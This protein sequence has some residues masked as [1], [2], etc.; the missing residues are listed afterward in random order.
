MARPARTVQVLI[1]GSVLFTFISYWRTAAIVLCDLGSTCYYIGG[2]VE[3]FIGKAAPWFILGVM[4]FSLAMN[5]VYVESC[6]LFVRGGVYRVVKE[7]LGGF[8]GKLAVSAL[9]FDYILTGPIS[10]VSAGQYIMG[11]LLETARLVNPEWAV[12][13]QEL[14]TQIRSIGSVLIAIGITLYFFRR[15]LLG[16][17]ESSLTALRIIIVT[18]VMGV[19]MIVWCLATLALRDPQLVNWDIPATPDLNKRAEYKVVEGQDP[20]TGERLAIYEKDA[21]GNLVIARDAVGQP[22]PKVNPATGAQEDPLGFIGRWLPDLAQR[23]RAP[24]NW[25]TLIGF[26][27][28]MIAFGHS[29]LAMSGMETMAQVYREVESPKMPNFKKASWI[30]FFFSFTLT[31]SISF[32]AVM[33]IPDEVRIKYYG[34][35]LIGGLA[36]HVVGPNGLRLALNAFVVVVGFLLLSGAVN[37]SIIGSNGVLN[38]VAEDGVIPAWLQRPHRK[39]GTTYRL[40]YLIVGLQILT[41]IASQGDV[42]VLGEAYAFGVIWSFTFKTM[43]MVVL[44]F[45]DKS[46]RE[47]RVP[48]NLKFGSFELPLGLILIFLALL[49]TALLNLMTKEVATVSGLAFTAI[50]LFIFMGTEY[51][52][53][54]RRRQAGLGQR[55]VEQFNKQSADVIAPEALGLD[56][57]YRKLVAIRSPQNLHMLEKALAEADPETT[58]V[59]VMTAKVSPPGSTESRP[60]DELDT[61]D[62]QLMTAVVAKAEKAGKEVLPLIVPTNNPVFA[63]I[64]TARDL[65]AQELIM[66]ASNKYTAEE[67]LDQVAFYWTSLPAT[68][69]AG[70][71][72]QPGSPDAWPRPITIRILGR[73]WDTHIDLNGGARI[74]TLRERRARSVA[75]LRAA[76]IGVKKALFFHDGSAEMEELYDAVLTLMDEAIPLGL[77]YLAEPRTRPAADPLED[78]RRAEELQRPIT[79]HQVKTGSL[80][81]LLELVREEHYDLLIYP[82]PTDEPFDSFRDRLQELVRDTPCRVFVAFPPVVPREVEE[83]PPATAS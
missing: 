37:T 19:I 25:L 62:Q 10:S 35:N 81:E 67:Q 18:G 5:R 39:Y 2:I 65:R 55:H 4:L 69:R 44:R 68:E 1:V 30:I 17:H 71:A 32:F 48:L 20:I 11:L 28:V 38:R 70:P 49:T 27:G 45:K 66:G 47:A 43:S 13:D 72:T 53:E 76:G 9:M 34:D 57:P 75:D 31:S 21:A 61:Y 82:R 74:P 50:F 73:N 78:L 36:M 46:P 42:L 15:N 83:D 77:A 24:T 63:I 12:A 79:P 6:S 26:L 58:D 59:I 80:A 3:Q 23:L 14:R 56:K 29:L 33:L 16:L 64:S 22:I 41:I 8:L 7:A 60:S 51:L 40:L 52:H 54:R